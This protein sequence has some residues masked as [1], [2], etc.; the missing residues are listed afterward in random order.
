M[1]LGRFGGGLGITRFLAKQGTSVLVTDLNA[2]EALSEPVKQ[3]QDLIDNGSVVLR[4]GKHQVSDF[5]ECDG[6]IAN[7]AVPRPWENQYLNA[8]RQAGVD[9]T[10]EIAVLIDA[11]PGSA[12]VVGVTGSA[13]KSTICAMI[14]HALEK[15]GQ[16]VHLGGNIGGSLLEK[17]AKIR[18][19]DVVVLEISS[20][21][22]YWLNNFAPKVAIVTSLFENHLDWHGSQAH[23][24]ACKEKIL[25]H[26]NAD[27][28][29]ILGPDVAHWP[30]NTGAK[31]IS[32]DQNNLKHA[33][34][35]VPGDHNQLNAALAASACEALGLNRENALENIGDFEGLP[36]RL[37]YVCERD[38]VKYYND[39][40]STTP[41]A[42]TL[43]IDALRP[44]T[45]GT[46]HVIVGGYDKGVDL[47]SICKAA[48]KHVKLYAIGDTQQA[49]VK[50]SE[51]ADGCGTLKVAAE[52][53]RAAAKARDV[54]LLS[55][56]CASW[57][58]FKNYELRGERFIELVS[59]EGDA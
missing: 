11:L 50:Q 21:M 56:G 29:A 39:S 45:Q 14:A 2:A 24:Q 57:D 25:E 37:A 40:K 16:R 5:V 13:G 48:G 27:S 12:S 4:L 38:G 1:G 3:I 58:Q 44:T 53:A 49:I 6:V 52:H 46:I 32:I 18:C 23:Y 15:N 17:L 19:E 54:V 30:L 42:T 28:F 8:A 34:L 26:Q 59:Q 55:P 9:I 41:N 51:G 10:T 7:P 43:A 31:R 33:P 20:A 35:R 47:S 22:L 36:H